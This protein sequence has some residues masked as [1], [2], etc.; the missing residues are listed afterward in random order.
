[1]NLFDDFL[2]K[3]QSDEET[4]QLTPQQK[5]CVDFR[6]DGALRV[7]GVA[8]SGKT[9][10]LVARA[11]QILKKDGG[12]VAILTYN[13]ALAKFARALA[14]RA[15]VKGENVTIAHLHEWM[16][17]LLE[18]QGLPRLQ[19]VGGKERR[20]KIAYARNI[21]RKQLG[22]GWRMPTFSTKEKQN[23]WAEIY[24]LESE[25]AWIKGELIGSLDEYLKVE[26]TGRG[27]TPRLDA[28]HRR[29]IWAVYE[30]YNSL[31][32]QNRMRDFDDV[33]V[34]FC[35][36][37]SAMPADY[38]PHH[39]LVDEAQDL[40][41]AQL[42]ALT[43]IQPKSL[44]IA[45]DKGQKIYRRNFSFL[46]LGIDVRGARSKQLPSSHRSTREIVRLA[47]SLQQRDALLQKDEEFVPN[48]EPDREGEKPELWMAESDQQELSV[49]GR[50]AREAIG[51]TVT[52]TKGKQKKPT[53]AVMAPT[54]DRVTEIAEHLQG[55]GLPVELVSDEVADILTP[56]LKVVTYHSAK[57]LEFDHAICTG[58]KE[59]A[60]P[61]KQRD[62]GDDEEA[63]LSAQRALLYVGLTRAK[64]RATLIAVKPFSQFVQELDK[65]YFTVR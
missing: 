55:L 64:H 60:L 41:R 31:L 39:I 48:T 50:L 20:D 10:V 12:R 26:R 34:L 15:G 65:R 46:Q 57:G 18:A 9:T 8:G 21:L 44:T 56:G 63:H 33:A 25:I 5:E 58:L 23:D 4:I 49:I 19:S 28:E 35:Q 2:K 62:P 42:T 54:K 38:R 13:R 61:M 14:L 27:R 36:H 11:E 3:L 53:V 37:A 16:N 6:Q 52:T 47:K 22:T 59:G 1:M 43:K 51:R 17:M 40:T 29:L 32:K 45:A 24:F 7:Q 30:K